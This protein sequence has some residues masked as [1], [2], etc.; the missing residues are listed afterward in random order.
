MSEF[1]IPENITSNEALIRCF[2]GIILF[3]IVAM[4]FYLK[5]KLGFLFLSI[6]VGIYPIVVLWILIDTRADGDIET[7]FKATIIML[8]FTF[9]T[10]IGAIRA[11]FMKEEK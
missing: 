9:L 2:I 1:L 5:G 6:L 3:N 10:G 8:Y 4:P 11:S 7:M